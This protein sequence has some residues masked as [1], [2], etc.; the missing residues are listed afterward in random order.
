MPSPQSGKREIKWSAAESPRIS[1]LRQLTMP[2]RT[3]HQ[4]Y[5][6]SPRLGPSAVGNCAKGM[7]DSKSVYPSQRAANFRQKYCHVF[8]TKNERAAWKVDTLWRDQW[9]ANQ[10][11]PRSKEPEST[12]RRELWAPNKAHLG[13]RMKHGV[14]RSNARPLSPKRTKSRKSNWSLLANPE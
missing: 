2:V 10:R 9:V 3:G 1:S 7:P 6:V 12:Q 5:Y 13:F 8:L 11:P 4:F 14:S